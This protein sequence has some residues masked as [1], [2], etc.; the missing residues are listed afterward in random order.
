MAR[1]TDLQRHRRP[2]GDCDVSGKVSG[3]AVTEHDGGEQSPHETASRK[4]RTLCPRP[5]PEASVT[6]WFHTSEASLGEG[7]GNFPCQHCHSDYHRHSFV[8]GT[9]D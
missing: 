3:Q 2:L 5:E 1:V 9:R 8:E 4:G 7:S 6:D